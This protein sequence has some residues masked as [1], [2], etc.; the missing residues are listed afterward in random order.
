MAKPVIFTNH[1]RVQM[2]LRGATPEEVQDAIRFGRHE[3]AKAGK[4]QTRWTTTFGQQ[5]AIN[6]KFYRFK[7]LNPIFADEPDQVVV[8][9]V[10]VFYH[11][12]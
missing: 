4:M 1:A 11:N 6:S 5:S 2:Q 7:T 8:I 9:T 10:K 3:S 12:E